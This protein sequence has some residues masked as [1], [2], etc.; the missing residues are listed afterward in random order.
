VTY[1]PMMEQFFIKGTRYYQ[2]TLTRDLLGD[3]V[4]TKINGRRGSRL[5]RI[6]NTP[7]ASA[8]DGRALIEEASRLRIAHGYRLRCAA[9]AKRPHD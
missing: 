3:W 9:G 6:R 2:I 4:V 1:H 7:V 5:G 8:R